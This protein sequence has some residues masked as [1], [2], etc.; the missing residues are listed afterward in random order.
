[1][2]VAIHIILI[3]LMIYLRIFRTI[4]R[5]VYFFVNYRLS[6]FPLYYSSSWDPIIFFSKLIHYFNKI[7]RVFDS[8]MLTNFIINLF[9]KENKNNFAKF[10]MLWNTF[11]V[12][13]GAKAL[14]YAN[15]YRT[16]IG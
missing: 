10:K 2:N 13:G 7:F 15:T 16:F 3:D 14:D 12:R 8:N 1:M 11:F 9:M 6:L 4:S 5:T